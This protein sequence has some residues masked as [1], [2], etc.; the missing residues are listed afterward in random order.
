MPTQRSWIERPDFLWNTEKSEETTAS[1]CVQSNDSYSDIAKAGLSRPQA[2][3]D[4][5]NRFNI[6]NYSASDMDIDSNIEE[7]PPDYPLRKI[8]PE[9]HIDILKKE[10]R[11]MRIKQFMDPKYRGLPLVR[12]LNLHPKNEIKNIPTTNWN[13][14]E[15]SQMLPKTRMQRLARRCDRGSR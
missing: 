13:G 7:A 4:P 1:L 5:K 14:H 12:N 9:A 2:D 6:E 15:R 3:P 11:E 10:V 8:W